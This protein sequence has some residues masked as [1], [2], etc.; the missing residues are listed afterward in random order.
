MILIIT[1]VLLACPSIQ[2]QMRDQHQRPLNAA[3]N[4]TVPAI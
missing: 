2:V 4:W 3:A 1:G